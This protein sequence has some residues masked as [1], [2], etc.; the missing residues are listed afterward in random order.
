VLATQ[1]DRWHEAQRLKAYLGAMEASVAGLG[2]DER[3]AAEEWLAWA[4]QYRDHVDPLGEQLRL[5][6][7]PEFTAE[8]IA[9]FMRGL[10]PYGPGT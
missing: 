6:P 9:P 1:V 7:D 5:P 8:V 10:S 4:R 2:A 3:Q